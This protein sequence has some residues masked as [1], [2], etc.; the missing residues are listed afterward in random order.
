[1]HSKFGRKFIFS[2]CCVV[3][4]VW[5]FPEKTVQMFSVLL[6]I[7]KVDIQWL[8]KIWFANIRY[9]NRIFTILWFDRLRRDEYPIKTVHVNLHISRFVILLHSLRIRLVFV[10]KKFTFV[11]W[12]I[13]LWCSHS[14]IFISSQAFIQFGMN[15]WGNSEKLFVRFI[16]LVFLFEKCKCWPSFYMKCML[17]WKKKMDRQPYNF[18]TVSILFSFSQYLVLSLFH[19]R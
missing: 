10:L 1:M 15:L 8:T 2:V 16:K 12:Q 7:H 4:I 18:R 19:S 14:R 11:F 5:K 13:S 6:T 17:G 3:E 9:E